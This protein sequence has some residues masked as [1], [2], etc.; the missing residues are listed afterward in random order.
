[1]EHFY[2][3]S[4]FGKSFIINKNEYKIVAQF[5]INLCQNDYF[6][7]ALMKNEL[8]EFLLIGINSK[9]DKFQPLSYELI[10]HII[11][12]LQGKSLDHRILEYFDTIKIPNDLS[13][14]QPTLYEL[15][16]K[17]KALIDSKERDI[18]NCSITIDFSNYNPMAPK[19]FIFV[20][21]DG[22][23]TS[24][25]FSLGDDL[26]THNNFGILTPI[27]IEM[28]SK[29]F[30]EWYAQSMKYISNQLLFNCTTKANAVLKRKEIGKLRM[31]GLNVYDISDFLISSAGLFNS[32]KFPENYEKNINWFTVIIPITGL[33]IH[34]D[35]GIGNVEF[36]R[37]DNSDI[38]ELFTHNPDFNEF[39]VFATVHIND[40][41]IFNAYIV[42]KRQIEQAI[43]IL[44]SLLKDDSLLSTYTLGENILSRD[45]TIFDSKVDMSPL[46]Y[47]YSPFTG[48]SLS[49][50]AL[51]LSKNTNIVLS[52]EF[53][54]CKDEIEKIEMALIKVN[55]TN[56]KDI[57]P[58]L[59][60]LK[61]VRKSWDA[62]SYED[63]IINAVIALE[64]I[65]S[66]ES[67]VPLLNKSIRKKCIESLSQIINKEDTSLLED[68][69]N[70][71]HRTYTETPFLKKLRNLIERLNIPISESEFE[72]ISK[73]R[74]IRNEIVHGQVKDELFIDDIYRLC[75]II[76]RIA[77]YKLNSLEV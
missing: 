63:R 39:D 14:T 53:I 6:K 46:V 28:G 32:I 7:F 21:F 20:A 27:I 56:D 31:K 2:N 74:K 8:D 58:L 73:A 48:A 59:N 33:T 30:G 44:I 22:I 38:K 68:V 26:Q 49:G 24:I 51:N 10:P 47:I 50:N 66:K 43:D 3:I 19:D 36:L 29:F 54:K 9:T 75:S 16:Q 4:L 37:K 62:T 52:N 67:D 23:N 61:W 71:F 18:F 77:F 41:K 55:G 11:K 45:V 69:K 65:V 5:F 17:L 34:E 70:K 35:F 13:T 12:S 15:S 60:S 1:M 76:S 72:L 64:F 40:S 25:Y 42:G 57:S